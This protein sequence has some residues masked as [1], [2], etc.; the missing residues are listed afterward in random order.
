MKNYDYNNIKKRMCTY[1]FL[2]LLVFGLLVCRLLWIAVFKGDEYSKAASNQREKEIRVS[3]PR[4]MIYDRNL[5][6]LINREKEL[7]M[8]I[9]HS[10]LAINN[11]KIL[12]YLKDNSKF[13]YEKIKDLLI[14][15][16]GIVEIPLKDDS[17]ALEGNFDGVLIT[18]KVNRYSKDSILSHVIGY[19]NRSEYTGV[20]GIELGYDSILKMDNSIGLVSFIVDARERPIPGM[21]ITKVAKDNRTNTNSV[22]L[23]IDYHVQKIVEKN[24]DEEKRKGAVVVAEVETGDIVAMVSRPDYN[25]NNVS[26]HNDSDD[27]NLYNKSMM[28]SYPPGSIFKIVILLAALENGAVDV[29]EDFYCEGYEEVNGMKF[30]C[31]K[32]E[33]HGEQSLKEA[34]ANSCNS[35]FIQLGK[36][37]GGQ[38][39]VKTAKRLGFYTDINIGPLKQSVGNLPKGDDLLGTGIGNISIGQ[40]KIEATPLQITN[41]TMI[42]A[43]YGVKKDLSIIKGI[44]TE[45]GYMVKPWKRNKDKRVISTLDSIVINDYMRE[46]VNTGTARSLDLDKVGGAAVK[47]GS[48]QAGLNNEII[49]GWITGYFPKDNPK[50]VITVFVEEGG[51]GSTSAGPIFENIA[52]EIYKL[53]N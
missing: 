13:S 44:V 39:I 1:S 40:G 27:M 8:F 23:T 42:M 30:H 18:N 2:V 6:P 45:E 47:T 16:K 36:R 3:L 20:S 32:E 28:V 49:H 41:M 22:Q 38:K 35:V 19:V 9:L 15:S 46:V 53:E 24:I 29:N 33:G 43:N 48:A 52:K 11:T 14:S 10:E 37:L 31:H 25:Q 5:I 50:Y 12:N 17:P 26:E 7:N 51:S 4:G 34:F 21:G